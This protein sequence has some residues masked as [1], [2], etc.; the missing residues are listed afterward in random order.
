MYCTSGA[1]DQGL[2][3]WKELLELNWKLKH[4]QPN[5]A[6]FF[7]I[8][9]GDLITQSLGMEIGWGRCAKGLQTFEQ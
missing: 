2:T 8:K 4:H 7:Q 1:R 5:T 3:A 6:L 9:W